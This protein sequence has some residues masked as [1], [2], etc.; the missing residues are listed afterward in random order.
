M[1]RKWWSQQ[2]RKES[3]TLTRE[4]SEAKGLMVVRI[5]PPLLLDMYHM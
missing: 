1:E 5:R 3:T 2:E 4:V